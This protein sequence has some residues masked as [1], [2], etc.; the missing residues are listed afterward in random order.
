MKNCKNRIISWGFLGILLTNFSFFCSRVFTSHY[1]MED[2]F[3]SIWIIQTVRN[4]LVGQFWTP[5]ILFVFISRHLCT[6]HP[7]HV[8]FCVRY[9]RVANNIKVNKKKIY[10]IGGAKQP[11]FTQT[12]VYGW[13]PPPSFMRPCDLNNL[14]YI[15]L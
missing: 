12:H 7:T 10:I 9:F 4:L 15:S 6:P 14:L 13:L 3:N 5:S 11:S 1:F 2:V 8:H